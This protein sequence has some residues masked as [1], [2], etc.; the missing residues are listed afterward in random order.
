MFNE[1]Q[2][3]IKST[4]QPNFFMSICSYYIQLVISILP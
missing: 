4:T 3:V 1:G 2:G